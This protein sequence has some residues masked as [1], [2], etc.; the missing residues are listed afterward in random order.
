MDSKEIDVS[1]KKFVGKDLRSFKILTAKTLLEATVRLFPA[2][3]NIRYIAFML[4]V[5]FYRYLTKEL[6]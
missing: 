6:M 4:N 5:L 1:T 3:T 2:Y